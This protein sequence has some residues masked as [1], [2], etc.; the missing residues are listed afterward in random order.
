[1]VDRRFVLRAGVVDPTVRQT[2]ASLARLR[3]L[4]GIDDG[5]VSRARPQVVALDVRAGGKTGVLLWT[6]WL[7]NERKAEEC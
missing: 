1:M 3:A 6:L 4:A 7:Q 5:D 2:R